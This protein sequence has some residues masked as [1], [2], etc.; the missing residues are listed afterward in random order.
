M[1]GRCSGKWK[2]YFD[3]TYYYNK[4]IRVCAEWQESFE[5][6]YG[7]PME[8]GYQSGYS[9]DRINPDG[10]YEPENCRWIPLNMN[11]GLARKKPR[12]FVQYHGKE[13]SVVDL[14]KQT[15]I[16]YGTL[17]SR[18]RKRNMTPEQAVEKGYRKKGDIKMTV[19]K[20]IKFIRE[21]LGMSQSE[22]ANTLGI[23]QTTVSYLEKIGSTVKEQHIR[24]ICKIHHVNYFWLTEEK[25]EPYL[26]PP[27]ILMED[28]I[29]EYKLDDIDRVI[30]EEYVKLDPAMRESVKQLIKNI[31]K[32]T[33]E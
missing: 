7:W 14:S 27:S 32:N 1:I 28:V 25:G 15:N 8:N 13:I 31:I 22:F 4:G 12:I 6:F 19:N 17:L 33:P 26:S 9:I 18:I 24:L 21:D 3:M 2:N 23:G 20:R 16:P 5:A 30:I 29:E 10:N 11:K